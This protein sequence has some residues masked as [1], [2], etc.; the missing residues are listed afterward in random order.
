MDAFFRADVG[1]KICFF[2]LSLTFVEDWSQTWREE[3]LDW[4]KRWWK[5]R[6]LSLIFKLNSTSS[7]FCMR[8]K[9][10]GL[11]FRTRDV[12]NSIADVCCF[13]SWVCGLTNM[14]FPMCR[15][16]D[17]NSL[18][19]R[20]IWMIKKNLREVFKNSFFTLTKMH[21]WQMIIGAHHMRLE[22]SPGDKWN[23]DLKLL[24]ITVIGAD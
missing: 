20:T 5:S 17:K 22:M 2:H 23:A 15:Q 16:N 8:K 3:K 4:A 12:F 18:R 21:E 7:A 24:P 9:Y 10:L 13:E 19:S 14:Q 1:L 6:W 11:E